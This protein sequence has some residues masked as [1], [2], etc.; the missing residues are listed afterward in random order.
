[1]SAGTELDLTV[2]IAARSNLTEEVVRF[3]LAPAPGTELP[4][5]EAGAHI[6]VQVPN[7]EVRKYSLCQGPDDVD[8]YVIAVKREADGKGGSKS[9]IDESSVGDRLRISAPV[10]DFPL[11]GNPPRYIFIAGGIGITPIYSMIQTLLQTGGKPF[12]L[13]Y[14][15]PTPERTPFLEELSAP[16]MRGKVT[17]HHSYGDPDRAFDLWPILEQPKG[18]HVYCCG[19]RRLMEEVRDMTGHWSSASVHFEDFGN[20]DVAHQA[21]DEPFTVHL[22]AD[23]QTIDVAADQ[24]ILDAL[25]EQ[26]YPVPS[27]CESGTCGTCRCDL[28]DGEVDHRDLV[29]SEEEHERYIMVCVSRAAG[30]DLTIGLPE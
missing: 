4:P 18:A 13:Y 5:A 20:S 1:M 12:K 10:N 16:S 9:L 28:I 30:G 24:S 2:T 8:G 29:L 25:N 17:I 14:L 21:D 23:G 27:S 22:Q 11:G 26:G 15:T 6:E 3:E 7:G 19:P